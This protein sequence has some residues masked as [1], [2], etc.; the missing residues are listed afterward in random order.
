M[1]H[2]IKR[3]GLLGLVLLT[4]AL[5]ALMGCSAEG[6]S[7]ALDADAAVEAGAGSDASADAGAAIDTGIPATPPGADEGLWLGSARGNETNNDSLFDADTCFDGLDNNEAGDGADCNDPQCQAL[8]SCCANEA[9]CVAGFTSLVDNDFEDCSNA[10]CGEDFSIFGGPFEPVV[11]NGALALQGDSFYDTGLYGNEALNLRHQRID[12]EVEFRLGDCANCP[13]TAAVALTSQTAPTENTFIRPIIGL[14]A[15]TSAGGSGG[16][17]QLIV[18][19]RVVS[20]HAATAGAW[21]LSVRPDGRVELQHGAET[22]H[23]E[24]VPVA[25]AHLVLYGQSTNPGVDVVGA[26]IEGLKVKR[27]I[28]DRVDAWS[29]AR[30]LELDGGRVSVARLGGVDYLAINDAI[31]EDA[32]AVRFHQASDG[33]VL[34]WLFERGTWEAGDYRDYSIALLGDEIYVYAIDAEDHLVR[35]LVDLEAAQVEAP[36]FV[37]NPSDLTWGVMANPVVIA[38]ATS[39]IVVAEVDGALDAAF[40]RGDTWVALGTLPSLTRGAHE[41]SIVAHHD[42]YWLHYTVQS[43]T[44]QR[45]RAMVSDQMFYWRELGD[46]LVGSGEM[47]S[48]DRFSVASPAVVSDGDSL[49]MYMSADDHV[50]RRLAVVERFSPAGRSR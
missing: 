49:R 44:R 48:V 50:L 38:T 22:V 27:Y 26:R 34:N 39:T 21:T 29:P 23:R 13:E 43:G 20:T 19:D 3:L 24:F 31:S 6:D 16:D 35:G 10:V 8:P 30:S 11:D 9:E 36:E 42:V 18:H 4:A 28:V 25:D 12:I 15:L 37:F 14:R 47:G 17:V 5:P 33:S 1:P 7:S 46:A 41:P 32:H 40:L 45:V 2:S